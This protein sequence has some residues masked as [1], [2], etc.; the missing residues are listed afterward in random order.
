MGDSFYDRFMGDGGTADAGDNSS[1]GGSS[2]DNTGGDKSPDIM[3]IDQG[4]G[5]DSLTDDTEAKTSG[6]SA[7]G[8]D[9]DAGKGAGDKGTDDQGTGDEGA[10]DKGGKE[11]SGEDTSTSDDEKLPFDQHP[12]WK[13]ARQAEKT[14]Q[15]I[16]EKH[17]FEDS[18]ELATALESG[19][20]LKELLGNQDAK[21]LL[22]ES[23]ELQR[24]H[25]FWEEEKNKQLEENE[26][27]EQ[28]TKRLK[29]ENER[30]KQDFQ[31]AETDR[32]AIQDSEKSIH[33]YENTI[34]DMVDRT[35]GLDETSKIMLSSL[36]GV[37]NP[38]DAVDIDDMK[39]VK[40]TAT[41]TIEAFQ[42]Y[43]E[44]VQQAAV[45][46]Y[47]QGQGKG[48]KIAGSPGGEGTPSVKS[49]EKGVPKGA[50]TEEVFDSIKS[51][52]MER[53]AELAK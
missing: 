49:E 5:S 25:N 15:D 16:M 8:A 4:Q 3:K 53:L 24:I 34:V 33:N 19:T 21:K 23:Q 26:S 10:D 31:R 22:E 48:P 35:E 37:D 36:L 28:T 46:A 18:D 39:S 40:K 13:A 9:A 14:M 47:V 45:D 30:L 50:K 27:P 44:N 2:V 32:K 29:E 52:L 41:Q 42:E 20:S 51:G 43:I 1:D 11:E 7:D 6:S 17:G 38:V 12:K